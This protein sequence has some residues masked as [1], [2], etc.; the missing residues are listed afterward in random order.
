MERQKYLNIDRGY[1]LVVRVQMSGKSLVVWRGYNKAL[2]T[3][4]AKKVEE[5]MNIS[6]S[7]FL[8]WYD[9]DMEEYLREVGAL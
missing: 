8:E 9:Y 5:L 7:A 3:K 2:G 1:A 6:K 4:I